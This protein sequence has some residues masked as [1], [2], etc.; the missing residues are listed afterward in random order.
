MNKS[1]GLAVTA[2]VSLVA[3]LGQP[4]V[5]AAEPCSEAAALARLA[6]DRILAQQPDVPSYAEISHLDPLVQRELVARFTAEEKA[7]FWRAHIESF[8][9][10]P[11]TTLQ[12]DRLHELAKSVTPEIFERAIA[13]GEA[14]ILDDALWATGLLS[15]AFDSDEVAAIAFN[16]Q[17]PRR[18][19]S[20]VSQMGELPTCSC[21]VNFG[22]DEEC[23]GQF[24]YCTSSNPPITDCESQSFGCGY[25]WLFGC[26]GRCCRT[27]NPNQCY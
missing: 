22:D 6:A 14:A 21:S 11:L 17:P 19:G 16:K 10:L 8:L 1:C 18:R 27:T 15:T 13:G 12:Q 4:P 23:F 5:H 25:L 2:A 24:F 7:R 20:P 26:D 9:D 3:I